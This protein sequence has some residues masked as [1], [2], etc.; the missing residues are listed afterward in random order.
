MPN[1]GFLS[2]SLV[3]C[4]CKNESAI[5]SQKRANRSC[6]S[7]VMSKLSKSL[8]LLFC[9]EQSEQITHGGS[10]E[11]S[12]G[13]KLL[14]LLF[15]KEQ[16]S[17]E[18]QEQFAC[19]IKKGKKLSKT[20]KNSNFCKQLTCIMSQSLTSL[21]FKCDESNSL[22]CKERCERITQGCSLK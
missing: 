11:K 16:M 20:Y 4:E 14:K 7:V 15:K 5:H 6:C 22:F 17:E 19:G 21:F 10:F 9:H 8:M 18:Q 12:E 13:S 2:D 3:F 1:P